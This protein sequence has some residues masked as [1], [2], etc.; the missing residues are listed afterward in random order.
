M[1]DRFRKLTRRTFLRGA[2]ACVALPWLDAMT[3][4][5]HSASS[6]DGFRP[7]RLAVLFMPNGVLPSHWTP[8]SD[9]EGYALSPS[10]EPLAPI[11]D[12]VLVLTG[13]R[14]KKSNFGE[15]H[16]VKTS[17]LLT[18]EAIR[19]TGGRDIRNAVSMDQLAARQ[20]EN[21]TRLPSIE[22]GT[23]PARHVVDMGFSTVYGAHV[24]WRTPTTPAP[25]EIHPRRAFDRLFRTL[26]AGA[27]DISVLDLVMEDA[28]RLKGRVGRADRQKL[29][30]YLDG[31]RELERRIEAWAARGSGPGAGLT[32][33][34]DR[35]P[36]GHQEH[37]DIMLDLIVSAFQS[38]STRVASFM[39]GNAVSNKDFSFL[40]GVKGGHHH[41][42]HH[43]NKPEKKRQYQLINRWHVAAFARLCE[44]LRGIKE[45]EQN[46]LE[47][48]VV[49]FASGLRDG[50]R[51]DPND[52]PVL[53][54]GGGGG[55]LAP[56]RHL[57]V[58]RH[59]PLCNL[60][61]TLLRCMG[62]EAERFGDSRGAL[63]Q[64]LVS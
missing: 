42:S 30:E 60:H 14:N 6:P 26:G 16:Y 35:W 25:K 27:S 7:S 59:T 23:E 18:G 20:V 48:S 61:L 49:L 10:L 32:R 17:G 22:L 4:W 28:A 29:D 34:A 2:G 3:P 43:E 36:G 52:L 63:D 11:K 55:R 31:V 44:R 39:F 54:A 37:V 57:R 50:N 64:L 1:A 8:K 19:K 13:M 47:N 24:S 40:D 15:G 21:G 62:V 53:V 56:G 58:P 9:G 33:P 12:R 38:G 5:A 46:A 51:H 41:L 45:G